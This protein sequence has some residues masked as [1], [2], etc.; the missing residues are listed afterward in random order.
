[1]LV[2]P[3]Q[4]NQPDPT[5]PEF[6]PWSPNLTQL[7]PN[8]DPGAQPDP[9]LGSFGIIK[10]I[11][12][13]NPN[14]NPIWGQP[15]PNRTYVFPWGGQP[16]PSEPEFWVIKSISYEIHKSHE[17]HKARNLLPQSFPYPT[18]K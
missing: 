3:I 9:K 6:G 13:L 8:L 12:V 7:N 2:Q 17:V 5:Q 4:P 16:D 14:L 11:I 10:Y 1:M 15:E 18:W